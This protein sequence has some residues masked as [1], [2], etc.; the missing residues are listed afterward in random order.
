MYHNCSGN[1]Y[2]MVAAEE[3]LS[4]FCKNQ[5]NCCKSENQGGIRSSK[6]FCRYAGMNGA[7]IN[8]ACNQT[9][10]NDNNQ[11]VCQ[12]FSF[13]EYFCSRSQF[14]AEDQADQDCRTEHSNSGCI[15]NQ[16]VGNG[17]CKKIC[18]DKF[19]KKETNYAENTAH[20]EN[21]WL[22]ASAQCS[23]DIRSVFRNAFFSGKSRSGYAS[24]K[25]N[26]RA[27]KRA[28]SNIV[29]QNVGCVSR[30]A[31]GCHRPRYGEYAGHDKGR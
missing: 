19:L 15:G 12:R 7:G 2:N 14:S 30:T 29:Q 20:K 10:T 3:R 23:G 9:V 31:H 18:N 27:E 24:G 17:S 28:E 16:A 5:A 25:R 21:R 8:S 22:V 1:D 26:M 4:D 13:T 11:R 6:S